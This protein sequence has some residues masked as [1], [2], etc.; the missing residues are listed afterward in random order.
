[1]ALIAIADAG[2]VKDLRKGRSDIEAVSSGRAS[3]SGWALQ[4]YKTF[5]TKPIHRAMVMKGNS[6]YFS[7]GYASAVAAVEAAILNCEKEYGGT[8]KVY[9]VDSNVVQGLSQRELAVAIEAPSASKK[10]TRDN[11]FI[12]CKKADEAPYR[13]SYILSCGQDKQ[14]TIWEYKRLQNK[15]FISINVYCKSRDGSTHIALA[16]PANG[17]K[18]KCNVYQTQ[19]TEAEYDRLNREQIVAAGASALSRNSS[20]VYCKIRDGSTHIALAYPKN[21]IIGKCNVYQTQITKAEY[22]RLNRER[23][24]SPHANKDANTVAANQTQNPVLEVLDAPYVTLKNTNVRE[25]PNIES[26]L[27]ATLP[28]GSEV[29]AL[30]KVKSS[31]WYLVSRNGVKLGY[32]FGSLL[33]EAESVATADVVIEAPEAV[34][35]PNAVAVIIGNRSYE[36]SIPAVDLPSTT[37]MQ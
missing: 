5:K 10:T 1:M 14:I 18:G 13:R 17:I 22:D 35:N 33:A 2:L 16:Y 25:L 8:C 3:A 6:S 4:S 34:R 24:L 30:G 36:G 11:S 31:N 15:E 19:I 20:G 28:K 12:Y 32:V 21:G 23:K 7:W 37:P 27:I 26:A 29:T 9:A